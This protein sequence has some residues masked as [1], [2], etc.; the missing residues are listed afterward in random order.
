M[1]LRFKRKAEY[2]SSRFILIALTSMFITSCERPVDS[3]YIDDG[4]PPSAPMGLGVYYAS[5]GTIEIVWRTNPEKD[6]SYYLI[7]RSIGDTSAFTILDSTFS[8]YFIDDS[9]NYDELYFY[10]I[11]AVDRSSLQSPF[12]SHVSARPVNRY[13]PRTPVGLLVL[14]R[15]WETKMIYIAWKL[16]YESD[17]SHYLLFRGSTPAFTP[18]SSHKIAVLSGFE[19]YDTSAL[20]LNSTYYY[21]LFAVD[22][23]GLY[24]DLPA[25]G[26]DVLLGKP[27]PLFPADNSVIP[28]SFRFRIKTVGRPCTYKLVIQS[29]PFYGE[30]WSVSFFSDVM[31]DTIEVQPGL[32]YLEY[33]RRYY[34]QVFSYTGSEVVPNSVSEIRSF[35]LRRN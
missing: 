15:N 21:K 32:Y 16:S 9:L 35:S 29:S 28:A 17:I 18:D 34:W 10:R 1:N 14:G 23:G 33:G 13:K 12:S 2:L 22:K 8:D 11:R 25:E 4:I 30:I 24:S 3:G 5:D 6:V 26:S 19:Y 31:N 20:L 7:E 27:E